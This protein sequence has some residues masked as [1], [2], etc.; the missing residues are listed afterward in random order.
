MKILILEGYR[1]VLTQEQY[2]PVGERDVDD[3][4][5]EYLIANGHARPVDYVP[6]AHSFTINTTSTP[7]EVMKVLQQVGYFSAID[8]ADTSNPSSILT[9]TDSNGAVTQKV[10]SL[11]LATA[12]G[13][14]IT[15]PQDGDR[16]EEDAESITPAP[17]TGMT[18][19][20]ADMAMDDL[21]SERYRDMDP[22]QHLFPLKKGETREDVLA[23]FNDL[24]KTQLSDLADTH[25]INLS[26]RLP[27][28]EMID[29]LL[30]RGI[31][32]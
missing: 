30:S 9:V 8:P 25:G 21:S 19:E 26:P 31:R 28:S 1:G 13:G 15:V 12:P 20:Q 14:A 4:I 29:D 32:P 17:F 22:V 3:S 11:P 5:S 7:V 6:P 2:W 16:D 18:R 23:L 10:V 24:T 27:K